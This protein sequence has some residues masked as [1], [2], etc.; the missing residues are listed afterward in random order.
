V[1]PGGL[2]ASAASAR[3]GDPD[4]VPDAADE[5]GGDQLYAL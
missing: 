4:E 1:G 2:R 3:Q 5:G